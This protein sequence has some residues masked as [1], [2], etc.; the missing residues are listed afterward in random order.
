MTAPLK[1]TFASIDPA[2]LATTE[3][4]IAVLAGPDG[5][6]DAAGRRLDRLTRGALAR[7]V[8]GVEFAKAKPG[9]G[10]VLAWPAGLAAAHDVD[11]V[12]DEGSRRHGHRDLVGTVGET[13]QPVRRL[14]VAD[15]THRDRPRGR[16]SV[17]A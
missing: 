5:K 6:L 9:S 10:Q 7:L 13:P 2:D 14:A 8:A 15:G 12:E 4:R 17:V 11:T 3:G 1:T 16:R